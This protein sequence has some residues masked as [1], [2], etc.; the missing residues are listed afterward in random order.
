MTFNSTS[1]H[2]VLKYVVK[3]PISGYLLIILL[4]VQIVVTFIVIHK[5]CACALV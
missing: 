1:S 3:M 5:Y 2:S 4:A